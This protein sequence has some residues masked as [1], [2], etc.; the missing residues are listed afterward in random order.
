MIKVKR[1]KTTDDLAQA[2]VLLH[3]YFQPYEIVSSNEFVYYA[4][5]YSKL[6]PGEAYM[7]FIIKHDNEIAGMMSG[8]LLKE[9]VAIDY[10][11]IDKPFRRFTK[12]IIS[13]LTTLLEKFS[14]PVLAEAE[15]EALVRFYK[16]LGF[17]Q[18]SEHYQ[19][20]MLNVQLANHTSKVITH[21][22][23]LMYFSNDPLDFIQTRNTL[24][25]KHY[26]RWN[27]IYPDDLTEKYKRTF[28]QYFKDEKQPD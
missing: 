2:L 8:V 16:I 11:I 20:H 5:N 25:K 9:F 18:F 7:V 14:R 27:G 6:Y 13:E 1:A 21:D 22:S 12:K 15:S 26:L 19:Y 24:Y 3:Q 10:L 23:H 28:T 4:Q 17:K